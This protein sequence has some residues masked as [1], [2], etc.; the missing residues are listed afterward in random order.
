VGADDAGTTV[1]SGVT[2]GLAVI[3][4]IVGSARIL[5][6]AYC[7]PVT[8]GLAVIGAIIGYLSLLWSM[9]MIRD[10]TT[11]KNQKNW[12][13]NAVSHFVHFNFSTFNHSIKREHLEPQVRHNSKGGELQA[14]GKP[15]NCHQ[16]WPT[17]WVATI[18]VK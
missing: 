5:G 3:G 6:W 12:T 17:N 7:S 11:I 14:L 13:R 1:G 18:Q 4:A 10:A 2:V 15:P 9:E 8:I 16:V